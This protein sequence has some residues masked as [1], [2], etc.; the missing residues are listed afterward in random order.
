MT[1]EPRPRPLLYEA[2]WRFAAERQA[3]FDRRWLRQPP[4]WTSDPILQTYKFCNTFRASD[5]VTQYLIRNVI[6]PADVQL[7]SEDVLLRIVL[8][9]LF[10]RP[11]TWDAME[12]QSGGL[13]QASFDPSRLGDLLADIRTERAIYT[14][15]FIVAPAR[16][17]VRDKHRDHLDLVDRMFRRGG[18]AKKLAR[19]RSLRAVYELLLEWPSVGPFMAY[20]IAVDLNYS[21]ELQFSEDDFCVP[22]PGALRGIRKVFA[23]YAGWSPTQ[24]I[25]RMVERQE[26]EFAAHGMTFAGLFG[27]P[28]HAVDCQSLFC[29]ID[30][31]SRVAFPELPSQRT[32]IKQRFEPSSESLSLFYPPKWGLNGLVSVQRPISKLS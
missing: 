21:D 7:A 9:R 2:Y 22:G 27:R 15:A 10:S 20:Q 14:A 11:T 8:F 25:Y 4:P 16:R 29:E 5:R 28:L 13:R 31:Y 24:L 19:A 1:V 3:I 23:D 32:R 12:K 18:F 6:H 17:S 30:K 26:V